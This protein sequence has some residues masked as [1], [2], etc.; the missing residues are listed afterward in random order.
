MM[1][2]DLDLPRKISEHFGLATLG[3]QPPA[4]VARLVSWEGFY[5]QLVKQGYLLDRWDFLDL[6]LWKMADFIARQLEPGEEI[7]KVCL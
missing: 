7:E 5:Q 2:V 6:G 4:T 1:H 3:H